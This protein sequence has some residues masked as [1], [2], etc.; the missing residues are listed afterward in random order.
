MFCFLMILRPPRSTRTDTL[1]PYTSL[2]RSVI[3][4]LGHPEL[5]VDL[6]HLDHD[7]DENLEQRA[8][9][10]ARQVRA[11]LAFLH[12]QSQLLE[13]QLGRVRMYRRYRTGM[14]AVDVAQ[15]EE[16]RPVAQLLEQDAIGPHEIGRAHV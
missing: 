11:A 6:L 7:I 8:Y 15:I 16:R 5:A 2:F 3:V 4:D 1:F 10:I 9:V 12:E 13:R 14:T